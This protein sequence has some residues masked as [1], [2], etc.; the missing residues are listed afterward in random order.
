MTVNFLGEFSHRVGSSEISDPILII[1]LFD[2]P[3]A[4]NEEYNRI[5][6]ITELYSKR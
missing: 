5:S 1:D 6:F 4:S 3:Y 2:S